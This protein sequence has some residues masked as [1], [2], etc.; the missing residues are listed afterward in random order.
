MKSKRNNYVTY[1]LS[2]HH[3]ILLE[4]NKF[5]SEIRKVQSLLQSFLLKVSVDKERRQVHHHTKRKT[6][7]HKKG[8]E[9]SSLNDQSKEQSL[10]TTKKE[11]RERA[12]R[13]K[14]AKKRMKKLKE[15]G[16]K[17]CTRTEVDKMLKNSLLRLSNW[18]ERAYKIM[19]RQ[20]QDI[21]QLYIATLDHN[22]HLN[23]T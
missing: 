9:S 4:G 2:E 8:K 7:T 21:T 18:S 11:K 20:M 1:A 5:K 19:D 13:E 16:H 12:L 3:R 6:K 15:G 23:C 10:R 17:K 14:K 22:V